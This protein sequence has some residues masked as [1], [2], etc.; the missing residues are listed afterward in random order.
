M[1]KKA[2]APSPSGAPAA[3]DVA[4]T[5]SAAPAAAAPGSAAPAAA[6]SVSLLSWLVTPDPALSFAFLSGAYALLAALSALFAALQF[7]GGVKQVAGMW[8][9]PAPAALML[10]YLLFLWRAQARARSAASAAPMADDKKA[11]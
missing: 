1:V 9:V 8:I 7:L 4:A 11:R 6:P 10:P 2:A 5:G 3:P